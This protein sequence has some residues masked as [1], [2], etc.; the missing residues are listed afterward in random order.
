MNMYQL[1]FVWMP[2]HF[3][4]VDSSNRDHRFSQSEHFIIH[5]FTNDP[6]WT[7]GRSN[8]RDIELSTEI[9][10]NLTESWTSLTLQNTDKELWLTAWNLDGYKC[11]FTDQPHLPENYFR[12]AHKL[13]G[14]IIAGLNTF[15][16]NNK[17]VKKTRLILEELGLLIGTTVD[18]T[19]WEIPNAPSYLDVDYIGWII[20]CYDEQ[21]QLIDCQQNLLHC[22]DYVLLP[23]AHILQAVEL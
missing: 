7:H 17:K 23:T 15:S 9:T 19:C 16:N 6:M 3:L 12:T 5:R 2:T 11:H 14:E 18:L 4:V 1:Q 10:R 13:Y 20:V 22:R 8:F 21:L